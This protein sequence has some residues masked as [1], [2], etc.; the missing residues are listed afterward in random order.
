MERLP[1]SGSGERVLVLVAHPDDEVLCAGA[2]IH[3]FA[4]QDEIHI[5]VVNPG[6]VIA[7]RGI[8]DRYNEK[9]M[10]QLYES[11]EILGVPG[12]CVHIGPYVNETLTHQKGDISN[13]H[14]YIEDL[15]ERL[16]PDLI[17]THCPQ[18]LHSAHRLICEA[19]SVATRPRN[20][21][22]IS[23][24]HAE[25]VG[26][27]TVSDFRPDVYVPVSLDSVMAK[28]N[29]M[30]RYGLETGK[31]HAI[32]RTGRYI[33]SLAIVRGMESGVPYAESFRSHRIYL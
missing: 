2:T 6:G 9:L 12:E 26:P 16:G 8:P 25:P 30:E 31:Y 1:Y 21:K 24:L 15:I 19:V 4:G 23:V 22:N 10:D 33:E 27:V 20:L 28:K 7:R 14:Y 29:A 3:R 17:I 11:A 32:W 13:V 18:D 5:A